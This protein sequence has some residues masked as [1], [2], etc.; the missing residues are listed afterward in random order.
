MK[1][2]AYYKGA[3]I[4]MRLAREQA[5]REQ[6]PVAIIRQYSEAVRFALRKID[7]IEKNLFKIGSIE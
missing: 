6:K 5:V 7:G 2:L 1:N 3:L 4:D